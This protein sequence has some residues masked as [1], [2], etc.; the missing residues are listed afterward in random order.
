M[1][2]TGC[3]PSL[4]AQS[5]LQ[6]I[7]RKQLI[8]HPSGIQFLRIGNERFTGQVFASHAHAEQPTLYVAVFGGSFEQLLKEQIVPPFEKTTGSNHSHCR[9]LMP[10]N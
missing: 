9:R 1:G 3:Q 10:I 8:N 6:L 2:V 4:N 7:L 5:A